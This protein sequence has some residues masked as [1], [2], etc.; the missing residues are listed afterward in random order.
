MHRFQMFFVTNIDF[1][2]RLLF[3]TQYAQTHT[4]KSNNM[5]KQQQKSVQLT[6]RMM[7]L[8]I[9]NPISLQFI[10]SIILYFP[11]F[12]VEIVIFK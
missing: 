6:N 4:K 7:H 2:Y 11:Y 5:A 12:V 10:L 8:F 3:Y 9:E 1:S